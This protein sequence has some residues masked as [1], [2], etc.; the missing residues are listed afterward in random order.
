MPPTCISVLTPPPMPGLLSHAPRA[1]C[2]STPAVGVI[3]PYR[4]QRKLL[5]ETFEEVVGKGPASEVNGL[6]GGRGLSGGSREA[7]GWLGECVGA[8]SSPC[9]PPLLPSP[10]VFIETVDSFQ[11]KQLDVVILSCVRASTGG[12]LGG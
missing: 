11:G 7:A 12:G 3:T 8:H 5:R 2:L 9:S 4:E 6:V 1:A 10:Q